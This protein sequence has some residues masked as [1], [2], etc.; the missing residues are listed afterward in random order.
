M[1][2]VEFSEVRQLSPLLEIAIP[3]LR[4]IEKDPRY[5]VDMSTWHNPLRSAKCHVCMA[6]AV[7][8]SFGTSP[9]ADLLPRE[10]LCTAQLEAIDMLRRG[11]VRSALYI[12]GLPDRGDFPD[13]MMDVYG[14]RD[15]YP[16]L[17]KLLADLKAAGL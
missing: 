15:F 14:F 6:G 4:Q 12:L 2:E 10:T 9:L 16:D 13:R 3:A 7:L 1:T 5:E 8:A 17:E 11:H